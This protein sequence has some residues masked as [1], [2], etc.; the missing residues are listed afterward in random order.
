MEEK[1][2]R[3]Y[4]TTFHMDRALHTK[5]QGVVGPKG[6]AEGQT[7]LTVGTAVGTIERQDQSLP[8][9]PHQ[10]IIKR[11]SRRLAHFWLLFLRGKSDPG[12]AR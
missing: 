11:S 1:G 3:A 9:R 2:Q 4:R 7:L 10:N 8:S 5:A 12:V 6:T